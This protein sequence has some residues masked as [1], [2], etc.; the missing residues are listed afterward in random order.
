M[1]FLFCSWT[2]IPCS[3]FSI[4]YFVLLLKN[5]LRI[6]SYETMSL[7]S[8]ATLS[9]HK[10]GI[11]GGL[12]SSF[13]PHRHSFMFQCSKK[14]TP[15]SPWGTL[16]PCLG[17]DMFPVSCD[18]DEPKGVEAPQEVVLSRSSGII[19]STNVV[20][21]ILVFWC[22][23]ARSMWLFQDNRAT[24]C[25]EANGTEAAAAGLPVCLGQ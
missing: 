5:E 13:Y 19:L 15:D 23:A 11:Y 2:D 21:A 14:P 18:R 8:S 24:V 3:G 20:T 17:V 6:R 10:S 7:C 22:T 1:L 16:P 9:S 12:Y 25:D 4:S